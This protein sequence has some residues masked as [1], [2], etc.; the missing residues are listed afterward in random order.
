[1]FWESSLWTFCFPQ[2][3]KRLDWRNQCF[4]ASVDWTVVYFIYFK[5]NFEAGL[6][7][8]W[9]SEFVL[10]FYCTAGKSKHIQNLRGPFALF[11][12]F[13]WS[14]VVNRIS[15]C[16]CIF[17]CSLMWT[18]AVAAE[19][20]L[21]LDWLRRTIR[22][23]WADVLI[24]RWVQTGFSSLGVSSGNA[25]WQGSGFGVEWCA[26]FGPSLRPRTPLNS[27]IRSAPRWVPRI[28]DADICL[29][30]FS[31]KLISVWS[32]LLSNFLG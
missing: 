29:W 18:K 9:V 24:Q 4:D 1:M 21:L 14:E 23:E 20:G 25:S 6:N 16:G 5:R 10:I 17:H 13:D 30:W 12:D 2:H 32:P 11:L 27:A 19:G 31:L 28:P 3:F 26:W 7:G 8:S 15:C 22:L